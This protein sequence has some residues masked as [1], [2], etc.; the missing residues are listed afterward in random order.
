MP[1]VPIREATI[2]DVPA[3]AMIRARF[4]GTEEYWQERI[5]GYL[6]R[7]LDPQHALPD[8][9]I[10]LATIDTEPVGLVAGHL[11]RRFECAGELQWIDV[12]PEHRRLG[13]ASALLR[14]Q[15]E[16]FIAQNATRVCVDVQPDNAVARSFYTRHGAVPLN[17]HWMVWSDIAAVLNR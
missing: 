12:L 7:T 11:T 3:L 10:F 4:W 9:V 17:P 13:I 14:K 1:D 15:A 16:W 8:R 6:Q 5:T 2:A